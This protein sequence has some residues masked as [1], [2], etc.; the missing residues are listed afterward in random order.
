M[1]K[2][3]FVFPGQGSQFV[4][5]LSE[6]SNAYP[7]VKETFA[8]ATEFFGDDLWHLAQNGPLEKLNQTE[9]TQ[10]V[11]VTAGVALWRAC[12]SQTDVKPI[13]LAGHSLG[14]YTALHCAAVF[15]FRE[16]V[17]LVRQ[18]AQFMQA[19]APEGQGA[20]AVII[21]L[22][23]EKLVELCEQQAHGKV[24][25]PAN[26][27]A[28]GQTVIAGEKE[29][30]LRVVN[31]AKRAG[32]KLVKIL[33]ISV[34]SHCELMR[35]AAEKLAIALNNTLMRLPQIPVLHNIDVSVHTDQPD[36][37]NALIEQL[38]MPVRWVETIQVM[39]DQ[40]IE[41]LIEC[42]PGNVLAGLIKRI[43][44]QLPVISIGTRENFEKA[45]NQMQFTGVK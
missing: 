33:P 44:S 26:F 6:F 43:N 18:R 23:D 11:L 19:V 14:E 34:P 13:L 1:K 28:I 16:A 17:Q 30:V 35:P 8:E 9:F 2:I 36:I 32:A 12:L 25:A 10:P 15:G 45:L 3:A 22:E 4:G 38:F 39:V 29:A 37:K 5:M 27:N 42:G 21:G 41:L 24:V 7:I 40:G 20:M 31:N